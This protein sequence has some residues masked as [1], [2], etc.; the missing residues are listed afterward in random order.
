[1]HGLS[2]NKHKDNTVMK[3]IL[4]MAMALL[5]L[6]SCV[7]GAEETQ[8]TGQY[9]S[10]LLQRGET[11]PDFTITNADHPEGISL[12]AFRGQYVVLEFWASWCPDCRRQTK[13]VARLHK[14]Y[15]PLGVEFVGVSFDTDSAAWQRYVKANA[16][17]WTQSCE[18][19]KWKRGTTTDRPYRVDW[20]P[21]FYLIDPQG[22]VA[23]ASVDLAK[24]EAAL[25]ALPLPAAAKPAAAKAETGSG[26]AL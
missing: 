1:M 9:D 24:V 8:D 6:N 23:A 17:E 5:C 21:A 4:L 25:K 16:M 10:Q 11:A 18:L 15:A 7:I 19:K 20:I 14:E 12:S 13:D 2:I 22:K 26:A 3:K